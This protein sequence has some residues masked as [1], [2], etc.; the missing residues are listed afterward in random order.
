MR[1]AAPVLP[2]GWGR[3]ARK[4]VLLKGPAPL[5]ME[6]IVTDRLETTEAA[7]VRGDR[8]PM[9]EPTALGRKASTE[10]DPTPVQVVAG[11]LVDS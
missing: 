6:G 3:E 2:G 5:P 4:Q 7:G 8:G 10:L 11:V 9:G 1:C